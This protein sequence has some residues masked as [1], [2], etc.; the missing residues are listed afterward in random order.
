MESQAGMS[1]GVESIVTVSGSMP[2]AD[3]KAFC[4]FG[5][6]FSMIIPPS[7]NSGSV[8]QPSRSNSFMSC[9]TRQS[10]NPREHQGAAYTHSSQLLPLISHPCAQKSREIFSDEV[11]VRFL[12]AFQTWKSKSVLL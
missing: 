6:K 11:P 5:T 2:N 8:F 10:N 3:S 9:I 7:S 1:L 12:I 4:I